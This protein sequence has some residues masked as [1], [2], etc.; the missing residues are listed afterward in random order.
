MHVPLTLTLLHANQQHRQKTLKTAT[1]I[2]KKFNCLVNFNPKVGTSGTFTKSIEDFK[3]DIH[4]C[5]I[6]MDKL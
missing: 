3:C 5:H 2:V 6:Y 4:C 1:G